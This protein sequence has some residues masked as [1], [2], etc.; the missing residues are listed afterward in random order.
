MRIYNQMSPCFILLNPSRCSM[1]CWTVVQTPPCYCI[2]TSDGDTA[3]NWNAHYVR[4]DVIARLRTDRRVRAKIDVQNR[5]GYAALHWACTNM[6][7]DAG[8]TSVIHLLLQ[9]RANPAISS[10][11]GRMPLTMLQGKHPSHHTAIALLEQVP[12]AEKTS[13]IVKARRL[14]VATRSNIVALSCLQD[15]LTRD[16]PLPCLALAPVTDGHNGKELGVGRNFPTTMEFLLGMGGGP[17]GVGMPQEVFREVL[18]FLM[19]SWD[20]LRRGMAGT[21]PQG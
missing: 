12:E 15:R 18:E 1:L 3:L 10:K 14:A 4:C 20:P 2:I 9:A 21:Q 5:E 16:E 8:S 17:E 7:D 19:P 13:L 6:A 11:I